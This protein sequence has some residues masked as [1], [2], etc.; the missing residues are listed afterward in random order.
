M[1][2]T[3]FEPNYKITTY[4]GYFF[5]PALEIF[6]LWK[7]IFEKDY[8]LTTINMAVLCGLIVLAMPYRLIRRI[9]F[10]EGS[11]SIEKYF[12]FSKTIEYTDVIDFG[13][14]LIKT[15]NGN[16][17]L[18]SVTNSY[19]LYNIFIA[20]VEK[21]KINRDQIENKVHAQEIISRKAFLPAMLITL[22]LQIIG[23]P[24]WTNKNST[25][26]N[27]SILF[28][29]AP[30]YLAIYYFLKNRADSE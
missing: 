2:Q 11:F 1:T 6:L 3:I 13:M 22:V 24:F 30:V 18:Y 12:W 16:I 29:F 27:L 21:G 5:I 23:S 26:Q 19:E 17:S 14:T 4:L 10:D 28:I 8:S 25:L 15:E 9:K 20:L 7:I